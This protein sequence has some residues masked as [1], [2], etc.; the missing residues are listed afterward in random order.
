LRTGPKGIDNE[1]PTDRTEM[2]NIEM[3]MPRL[4][5]QC[6]AWLAKKQWP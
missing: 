2:E 4:S 3:G 5:K 1:I 6:R